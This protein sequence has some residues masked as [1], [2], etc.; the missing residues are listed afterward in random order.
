MLSSQ[1]EEYE[2]PSKSYIKKEQKKMGMVAR[3]W[4][5]RSEKSEKN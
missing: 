5:P 4:N 1:A 3:I 2:Y